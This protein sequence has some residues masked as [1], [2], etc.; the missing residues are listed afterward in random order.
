MQE[1]HQLGL[2][3]SGGGAKGAAH[4]GVL[5]ALEERNIRPDVVSGTSAG[6][7]V[8]ALYCAGT[9][10]DEILELFTKTSLFKP[11][12]YTWKKPGLLNMNV[13]GKVLEPYFPDD[14]FEALEIPC[15]I[16]ATDITNASQV[17]FSEG[18]LISRI[19]ASA[20]F[21]IVFAPLEIDGKL[22][23]D[24]G[25][26]NNFP[27]EPIR[28]SCR[29]LIGVN[30]QHIDPV[31]IED[32]NSTFVVAQRIYSISTRFASVSK[33]QNCDVVIAP[34]ELNDYNTFDMYK[35]EKMYKI[36]YDAAC[37]QLDKID[38]A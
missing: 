11:S 14:N 25:I 37:E 20:C 3:L 4:A 8:G 12:Y 30:I 38:L 9:S 18:P 19:L 34:P 6:A 15:Y 17:V 21:P 2:V 13:F 5:K 24:G 10:S 31:G 7:I 27:T 32:L 36:G 1:D 33:Y 35:I 16:V 26:L 29:K 23:A 28:Q 22:Y